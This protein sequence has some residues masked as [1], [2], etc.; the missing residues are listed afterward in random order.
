MLCFSN[1]THKIFS[2]KKKKKKKQFKHFGKKWSPKFKKKKKNNLKPQVSL[3]LSSHNST[4]PSPQKIKKTYLF[5]LLPLHDFFFTASKTLNTIIDLLINYC[6][7]CPTA[8][9]TLFVLHM[10]GFHCLWYIFFYFRFKVIRNLCSF[11][12]FKD[13]DHDGDF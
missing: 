11:I 12:W 10:K 3:L 5:L 4:H 9:T 7:L 1:A 2:L 13:T 8:Q 6:T